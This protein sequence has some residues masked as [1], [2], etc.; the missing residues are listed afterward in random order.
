MGWMLYEGCSHLRD[1]KHTTK[2]EPEQWLETPPE[3]RP[4]P[5]LFIFS[6]ILKKGC[7]K[8]TRQRVE[9]GL[10]VQRETT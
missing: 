4:R 7:E 8:E 5:S 1:A 9:F 10:W 6:S 2:R 3:I